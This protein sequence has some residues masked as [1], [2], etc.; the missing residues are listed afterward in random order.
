MILVTG[1]SGQLAR[2]LAA[3]A[4]GRRLQT[5]GRPAFDF[6]KPETIAPL[7]E[8]VAPS[9]VV[10]AAAYTAVDRAE[11]EPDAAAAANAAGPA[12]IAGWCAQAG[13]P[14]IHI[15]T[16]YVFDGRKGAPYVEADTT[17]PT[18]VYGRTK[19]D[20]ETAV[21]GSGAAA[22]V[23]RTSWL[24][25]AQGANFVRTMLAAARAGRPLRVVD[26]QIGCP[27]AACDL[28]DAVLV[29]ADRLREFDPAWRGVYHA[30]GA[31]ETSW[32]G[33][34]V[35]A[36]RAAGLSADVVP[37]AT[38]AWPTKASRPADSR[39]DCSRLAETFGH[40]LPDWRDALGRVV[41]SMPA[42]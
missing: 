21:L 9:L 28:A 42:A 23:L 39:L 29:V 13:V 30:A 25:A 38:A 18:G 1:A 32:H 20:G 33:L 40:R 31:G 16:D 37:V 26:D 34:A 12:L 3:A 35:A 4:G 14:L 22:V 36:I 2:E 5:V 11:S 41:R 24:Y 27:T 15:S 10:N 7:L 6:A 19:R 17:N 8:R